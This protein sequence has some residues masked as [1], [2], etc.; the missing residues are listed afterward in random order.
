M[1][2][3]EAGDEEQLIMTSDD[4][5]TDNDNGDSRNDCYDDND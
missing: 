2:L 4:D 1:I 5:S 3:P